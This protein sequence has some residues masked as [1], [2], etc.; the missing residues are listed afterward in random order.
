MFGSVVRNSSEQSPRRQVGFLPD[1]D[2]GHLSL[3]GGDI[4]LDGDTTVEDAR[5]DLGQILGEALVF[6]LDLESQLTGVAEDNDVHFVGYRSHKVQRRQHE[7]SSLAHTG[8][9]LADDVVLEDG[10][11]DALVLHCEQRRQ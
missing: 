6:L 4:G 2:V 9:G 8:L 7:D 11:G 1:D 5:L 10:V 3:Q